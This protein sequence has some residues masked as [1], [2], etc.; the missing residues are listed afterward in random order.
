MP[1]LSADREGKGIGTS[2]YTDRAQRSSAKLNE[3]LR[4]AVQ[5]KLQAFI[6]FSCGLSEDYGLRGR[7]E[8]PPFQVEQRPPGRA[9]QSVEVDQKADVWACEV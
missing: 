4:S 3:W 8:R 2:V 6:S 1:T 5:S 7:E 9:G